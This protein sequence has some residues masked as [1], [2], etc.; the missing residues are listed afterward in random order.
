M[1]RT[2]GVLLWFLGTL[3]VLVVVLVVFLATFDWNRLKPTLNERVSETLGRPFAVQGDLD[4]RWQRDREAPGWRSWFPHPTL[5]AEDITLGNAEWGQAPDFVH[6]DSI[7][8]HVRPLALLGKR[9]SIPAI[10][11]GGPSA[12]IERL[13]DG[14]ANWTF[15]KLA[16]SEEGEEEKPSAWVL[17]IGTIG[18][19]KGSVSLDDQILR[20]QVQVNVTPLGEP[21]PYSQI[22]AAA[23]GEGAQEEQAQA[24][25]TQ[26]YAFAWNAEGRYGGQPVSGEGRVGGLLALQDAAQPFPL[27]VDLR[28]GKTR[29]TVEGTLS[30]PR[31]LGA[32]D[33][34]L[35]LSGDSLGNLY[36]LIGVTLPDTGAYSTDGRLRA[37]LQDPGGASFL[38][39]GF[40]GRIGGSDISGDLAY[41]ALEPRP[42]LTGELTSNQLRFADLAP[43]I[44]ADSEQSRQARGATRKQ[45]ADRALPVEE[46]RT[47]RWRDMDADVRFVGRRIIHDEALPIRDLNAHVVL[48]DGVLSLQPLSFGLAGGRLETDVRLDGQRTPLAGR[49][50]LEARALKLN[51]LF[52]TVETMQKSLGELNGNADIQGTGNS[53]AALLGSANGELRLL[54]ND[55]TVSRSLMELAGLNVGNY[56]VGRLFGDE[57][58]QINCAVIDLGM[59]NGLAE[60]RLFVFDTENAV[61]NVTGR[62]NFKNENMDLDIVPRS[63]GIRIISLRSPLYVR[64]TLKDPRPGVHAGPLALRGAGMIVLGATVGPAA[65]LL[66]LVAP[67]GG[68][69][70]QCGPLLEQVRKLPR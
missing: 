57:E 7:E 69:A 32:L 29:V 24:A 50:R 19:D 38:Y 67:S 53:V 23:Q 60:P 6:L 15:E 45:P 14:R 10:T 21:V 34:R 49:V 12:H 31:N 2:R 3:A 4:V 5:T 65:G 37:D 52:P 41:V 8:A 58:V 61:I 44:G 11:L 64:G 42:K 63:K 39:E 62:V 17:D 33:L 13:D 47:D 26:D 20:A 40:N 22:M 55:G 36:P 35:R 48:D 43:L 18:F 54:M 68:Q 56:L 59:K 70:D 30:D 66:A 27:Q 28:A 16:A 51:Q 25:A 1:S 46:F 9:V